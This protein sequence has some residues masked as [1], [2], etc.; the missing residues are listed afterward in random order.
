[1]H[2]IIIIMVS[3]HRVYHYIYTANIM[4][5]PYSIIMLTLIYILLYSYAAGMPDVMSMPMY[6]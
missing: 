5:S 2:T 1:M 6:T 3:V 4:A